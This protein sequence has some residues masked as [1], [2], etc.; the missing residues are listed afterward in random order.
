M[1]T[2]FDYHIK[3]AATDGALLNTEEPE[4]G[5]IWIKWF[6]AGATIKKLRDVKTWWRESRDL[7]GFNLGCEAI[8]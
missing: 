3:M 1:V 8:R 2:K 6:E 4:N 5:K 7:F